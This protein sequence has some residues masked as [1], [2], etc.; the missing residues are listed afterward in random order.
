LLQAV[1]VVAMMKEKNMRMSQLKMNGTMRSGALWRTS[2]MPMLQ[3]GV[4]SSNLLSRGKVVAT[5]VK[6]RARAK[7]AGPRRPGK[8]MTERRTLD[9]LPA[10]K[11]VTGME[12]QNAQMCR[13]ERMLP[14]NLVLEAPAPTITPVVKVMPVEVVAIQ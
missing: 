3:A 14:E 7:A 5:V 6:A 1:A 10:N 4:P 9:V 2:K 11:R 13:V 12:T 8:W